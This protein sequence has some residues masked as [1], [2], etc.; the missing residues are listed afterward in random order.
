MSFDATFVGHLDSN[1]MFA[2][3]AEI[4]IYMK[5]KK[6]NNSLTLY[7]TVYQSKDLQG[8]GLIEQSGN[9]GNVAVCCVSMFTAGGFFHFAAE[10]RQLCQKETQRENNY[11]GMNDDN[12]DKNR[13]T[14]Y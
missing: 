5:R 8:Q 6:K 7:I 12:G 3:A 10:Y 9:H 2:P 4:C 14:F 11:I 1:Q 13:F